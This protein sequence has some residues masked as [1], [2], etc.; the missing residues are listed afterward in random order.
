MEE[1]K[2]RCEVA[3]KKRARLAYEQ[4]MQ[5]KADALKEAARKAE[6]DKQNALKELTESLSRKLRNEAALER[7]KAVAQALSVARVSRNNDSIN[8]QPNVSYS[9][10]Y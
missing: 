9:E 8:T 3:E 6:E 10:P 2:Y 1:I 5:E 4:Y 7:E